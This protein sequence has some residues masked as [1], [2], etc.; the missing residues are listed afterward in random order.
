MAADVRHRETFASS[1][2]NFELGRVDGGY[3]F[4][5][6]VVGDARAVVFV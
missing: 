4:D 2:G 6:A 5:L 1:Q 3:Q